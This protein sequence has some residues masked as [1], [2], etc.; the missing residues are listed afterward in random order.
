MISTHALSLE[1]GKEWMVSSVYMPQGDEDKLRFL[2]QMTRFGDQ[3]HLL[4]IITRDFNL[5]CS[6]LECS[7]WRG[8]T[9]LMSKFRH[10]INRLGLHDSQ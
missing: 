9:R 10:S 1:D 3:V 5:I 8:N 6:E 2:E 4:W 7:S